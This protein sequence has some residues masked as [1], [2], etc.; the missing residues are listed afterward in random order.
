M[1]HSLKWEILIS[2]MGQH[3]K[4]WIFSFG[5]S[6]D[7][8][9]VTSAERPEI[10]W[11]N[12]QIPALMQRLCAG[13]MAYKTHTKQFLCEPGGTAENLQ[14]PSVVTGTT[15]RCPG[16]SPQRSLVKHI[17]SHCFAFEHKSN[18]FCF[19]SQ[20]L[21][22]QHTAESKTYLGDTSLTVGRSD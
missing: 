4:K 18:Y 9:V 17:P 2:A 11:D 6:E 13:S 12:S 16:Q 21:Q 8:A 22:Q 3:I 19:A 20:D 7:T 1:V 10:P 15:W 5:P 14:P